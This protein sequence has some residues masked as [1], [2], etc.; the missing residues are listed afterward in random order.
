MNSQERGVAQTAPL[1]CRRVARDCAVSHGGLVA[2]VDRTAVIGDISAKRAVDDRQE[3]GGIEIQSAAKIP[4][5]SGDDR[6]LKRQAFVEVADRAT[7]SAC[8][9]TG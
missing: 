2:V 8:I 6:A 1:Y 4:C 9:S 5:V 3:A 7:I